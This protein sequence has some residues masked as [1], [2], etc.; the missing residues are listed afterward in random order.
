SIDIS[1]GNAPYKILWSTL[2]TVSTLNNLGSG[3]Y[4]VTVT[5]SRG[6]SSTAS[7]TLSDPDSLQIILK[8]VQHVNCHGSADGAI[9]VSVKGGQAP[10]SFS[11][12]N[13][14]QQDSSV[15]GLQ[16]GNYVLNVTDAN[17]CA[18]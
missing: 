13:T 14:P 5:D 3:S 17:G 9:H 15:S 4:G 18:K 2:D 1:G 16:A 12:G 6:C 7:F 10:Y 11:W 8:N